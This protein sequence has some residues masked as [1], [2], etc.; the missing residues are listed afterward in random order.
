MSTGNDMTAAE[1]IRL[2]C[3]HADRLRESGVTTIRAGEFRAEIAP[4]FE[5][6]S[7]DTE[8]GLEMRFGGAPDP[9][10]DPATFPNGMLPTLR[11]P[12]Q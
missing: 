2:L 9:I 11:R 5:G 8:H 1:W 3:E 7:M 12:K 6:P 4:R 10:D